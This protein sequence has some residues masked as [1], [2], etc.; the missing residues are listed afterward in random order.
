MDT[1]QG[2]SKG[3]RLK[4]AAKGYGLKT[5]FRDEAKG[6]GLRKKCF[7]IIGKDCD[8]IS[9]EVLNIALLWENDHEKY[10]EALIKNSSDRGTW[11]HIQLYFYN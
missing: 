1:V 7:F 2:R 3:T 11:D 9:H 10:N 5:W 8:I 6:R 4:D